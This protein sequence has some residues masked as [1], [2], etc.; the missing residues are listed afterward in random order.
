MRFMGDTVE[1]GLERRHSKHSARRQSGR[2]TLRRMR[3]FLLLS[4]LLIALCALAWQRG[5]PHVDDRNLPWT[6]LQAEQAP[7]WLTGYKLARFED[8]TPAC[9]RFLEDSHL[10]FS[11]L[12]DRTTG[13]GCGFQDAVRIE[14]GALDYSGAFSL[15]CP[16]AA[17]LAVFQRHE[18]QDAAR[19]M[20]GSTVTRIDHYGSYACRN[21]YGRD[22]GRR[23]EHA[24]ANAFDFAGVR[25][26]DG[27][28]ISV[29]ADWNADTEEARF[30]HEIH[31]RACRYFSTV[32]G[33]GYNAAHADHFHL[34]RRGGFS[35][36]R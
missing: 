16:M 34:D 28:R 27:R 31:D 29:A 26:A 7:N 3:R 5:A 30:L 18:L 8:D 2:C 32:L 35:V 17:S 11:P 12:E 10:N 33:P 13:A 36:C 6:P 25:L 24:T 1:P 15:S 4:I 19:S 14:S 20:L 23:S 9:L 21:L 22:S